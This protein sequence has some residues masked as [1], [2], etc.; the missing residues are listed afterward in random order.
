[1]GEGMLRANQTIKFRA[2]R[3]PWK[4]FKKSGTLQPHNCTVKKA[5][6]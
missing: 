5:S 6:I 1:M 2:N 4:L 3:S